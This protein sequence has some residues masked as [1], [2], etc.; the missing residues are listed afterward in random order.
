LVK[1]AKKKGVA[2]LMVVLALVSVGL[3]GLWFAW[4]GLT[5]KVTNLMVEVQGVRQGYLEDQVKARAVVLREETLVPAPGAGR[6][7]NLTREGERVRKGAVLGYFYPEQGE[8]YQ[9]MRAPVSGVVSY[10][11]DGLEDALA[12][13]QLDE[14][15]MEVFSLQPARKTGISM[16]YH[17]GQPLFKVIDNLSPTVLLATF[18]VH[19]AGKPVH[20]GQTLVVRWQGKNLGTATVTG[21]G[22]AR[23]RVILRLVLDSFCD[24]LIYHR[25]IDVD[26]VARQY[27]GVLIPRGAITEKNGCTGVYYLR[28]ETVHFKEVKVVATR[29]DRAVVE[30]IKPGD[31][32]VTTPALVD[33]GMVTG[34]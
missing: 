32:V 16:S 27:H 7:E 5:S 23:D 12:A 4:R 17:Q 29:G 9:V 26:L 15:D 10:R 18:P 21:L 25:V 13:F 2:R 28:N 1:E 20:K 30:G 8:E 11:P 31:Y 6:F 22:R 19:T 14:P 3:L 34:K 24:D 33:E